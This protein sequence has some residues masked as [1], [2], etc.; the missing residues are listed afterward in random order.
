[1]FAVCCNYVCYMSSMVKRWCILKLRL[2]S[3]IEISWIVI[4]INLIITITAICLCE[5]LETGLDYIHRKKRQLP[6][7]SIQI[8]AYILSVYYHIN[9]S[10]I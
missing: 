4:I 10:Y 5:Y 9:V 8:N 2:I 3:E 7:S 6:G 1:V